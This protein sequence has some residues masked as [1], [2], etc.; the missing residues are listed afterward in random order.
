MWLGESGSCPLIMRR[1]TMAK[2][3]LS[4]DGVE[5]EAREPMTER[6]RW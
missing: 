4:L 2:N 5:G 3:L 6:A 1:S